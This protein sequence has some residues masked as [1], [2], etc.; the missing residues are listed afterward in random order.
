M[1]RSLVLLLAL[2]LGAC[3]TPN[4]NPRADAPLQTVPQVDLQRYLG[5]WYVIANIPYFAESK[6]VGAYVEYS[7][8]DDGRINDWY[9]SRDKTFSA[10]IEKTEG[11]AWVVDPASNA[12]LKVQFWWPITADYLILDVDPEYRYALIGHPSKEY[13]WIFAREPRIPEE[14]YQQLRVKFY[15][16]GYD[17]DR[18]LKVPQFPEDLG[19][20]GYQ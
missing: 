16:Q 11:L 18:I 7:R 15:E 2:A 12:R 10:P 1:N 17:I 4:S 3:A 9:F 20:P 19:Q 13:A 8:R 14:T 5:K 6:Q